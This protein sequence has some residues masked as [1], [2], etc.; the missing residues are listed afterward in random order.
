MA[1]LLSAIV[2]A[3]LLLGQSEPPRVQ[4]LYDQ[5]KAAQS[6]GDITGAIADYQSLLT[7]GAPDAP[8]RKAAEDRLAS[9]QAKPA[10]EMQSKPVT[11]PGKVDAPASPDATAVAGMAPAARAQMIVKMVEGLAERLKKDGNDLTGW[12]KLVRAYSVLGRNSD[13]TNA[14]SEAR[15]KFATDEKSLSELNDLAKS[16]GLGS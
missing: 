4:E 3:A 15:K 10:A 7:A 16:L 8:W 1:R 14:L 11:E 6:K 2:L 5:A 9:L 12:L 13:A